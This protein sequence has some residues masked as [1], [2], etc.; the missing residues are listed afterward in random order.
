MFYHGT[1]SS[2]EVG[3]FLLPPNL[4]GKLREK[5]T[6]NTDVV[7][8]SKSKVSANMYAKKA[9]IK[10]GGNPEIYQAVPVGRY[11]EIHNLEI[12]CGKAKIVKKLEDGIF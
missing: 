12:V 8:L 3:S 5:R 1:S 7:F 11:D 6:K 9:C 4:T 10:Y 2:F